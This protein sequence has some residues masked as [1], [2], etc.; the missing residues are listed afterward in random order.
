MEVFD[1]TKYNNAAFGLTAQK[2][3]CDLYGLPLAKKASLQFEASYC[4]ELKEFLLPVIC[5]IFSEIGLTPKECR[6]FG[7]SRN[8]KEAFYPHNFILE[9]GLTMSIRTNFKGDKV[10]PRVVG[11]CGLNTFNE[12]FSDL[13]GE[14]VDNKEQ[15]KKI[16]N[17]NIHL[18]LPTFLDYLFVSDINVWI[19]VKDNEIQYQIIDTSKLSDFV[20]NKANFSFTKDLNSWAESTTLKYNGISLAEIQIHTKRTFK[21]RFIMNSLM[22][23]FREQKNNNETLGITAEKTVCDLFIIKYPDNFEKRFSRK[24][25]L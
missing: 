4:K 9:N 5:N 19:F 8:E 1:K 20:F 11:Q 23:L 10:A 21:F 15:I 14:K 2:L 24:I 17:N 7:P 22:R 3:I 12:H 16:I 6:T 13:V 18:M 25:E